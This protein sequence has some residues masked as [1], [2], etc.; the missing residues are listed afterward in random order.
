MT[1]IYLTKTF[2]AFA[3]GERI[4]DAAIIK[5]AREMQ[6][7][8]YDANLG[9]CAYKKRIARPGGGKRNGYR[10][11]IASAE[12]GR[13]FFMYGFAKNEREN[14]NQDELIS[15]RHLAALYLDYSPFRLYQL[16]NCGELRRL[17]LWAKC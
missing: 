9:G 14:I 5:A 3:A 12:E 4:R 1:D 2:Q 15:W 6:N 10:V 8:L 7:Q 16:V 17:Q 13:L 11:P